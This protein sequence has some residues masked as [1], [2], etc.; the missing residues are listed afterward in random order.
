MG[1]IRQGLGL[2]VCPPG[3]ELGSSKLT[4]LASRHPHLADAAGVVE[5]V[6]DGV[7]V[8]FP[9]GTLGGQQHVHGIQAVQTPGEGGEQTGL[10]PP[11]VQPEKQAQTRKEWPRSSSAEGKMEVT[12][13]LCSVG[14]GEDGVEGWVMGTEQGESSQLSDLTLEEAGLS[15][16]SSLP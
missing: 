9:A 2:D 15:H 4:V 5:A 8:L 13:S 7:V 12:A 16:L 11:I 10:S 6:A 14:R 1:T 3:W